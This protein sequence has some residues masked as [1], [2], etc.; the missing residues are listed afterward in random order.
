[1]RQ[2]VPEATGYT[3]T[4]YEYEGRFG[5]PSHDRRR[6]RTSFSTVELTDRSVQYFLAGETDSG[7]DTVKNNPKYP[8]TGAKYDTP[9]GFIVGRNIPNPD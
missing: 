9:C 8:H 2:R 1:M 7:Q 3:T 5:I 4:H 6:E